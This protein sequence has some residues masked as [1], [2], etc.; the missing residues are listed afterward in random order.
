MAKTKSK[1]HSKNGKNKDILRST[2]SSVVK[3]PK[4]QKSERP[5]EDLLT[6]ATSLFEQ[7][8]PEL[9]LPLAEEALR[10]LEVERQQRKRQENNTQDEIDTLLQNAAQGKPTLPTALS[11]EGEIQMALGEVESARTSFLR[12]TV[13]DPDGALVSAEP[14]LWLAQLSE[15][16]GQESISYFT[17]AIEVLRN[18]IDVLEDISDD[19]DDDVVQVLVEKRSKLAN[20]L[21]AMT[22]VYMTDLSW[23]PDAEQRCESYITE[24]VAICPDS[25]SAGVLQTLASVRIS[26]ERLDDARQAL[27]RSMEIW[28]DIPFEVQS[29]MRPD[30]A[31][32]ISL[33]RLLMEV[34]AEAE[35]F[36]VLQGLIR[37]DDQS[38]ESWYL[39]GWCQVLVA[40]KVLGDEEARKKS[41]EQ[42]KT[43][44]D[45]CLR[46]FRIQQYEDDRLREHALELTQQLNQALG[47]EDQMDD[48]DNAW[49]DEEDDGESDGDEDLEV[50]ANEHD[51]KDV[52]MT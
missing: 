24:A 20:A 43:W 34:E 48:D 8:Q 30:F 1:S 37:E 25:L 47:I 12:A 26:Q 23:E 11:L 17:K 49:E 28:K 29:E 13:I 51:D 2:T 32:R 7:S 52:E 21:A 38:V 50:E 6:E 18:E 22:E 10:R 19:D 42:A 9:A 45:N 41:Q 14:Y 39:G 3:S 31:T 4:L 33:S 35:A 16:G 5:I 46:L 15:G 27:R 40:Q 44:L 36:G